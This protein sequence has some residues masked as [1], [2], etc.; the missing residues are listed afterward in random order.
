[1]V[2]SALGAINVDVKAT[3]SIAARFGNMSAIRNGDLAG[4]R[5]TEPSLVGAE[6]A[7]S[8]ASAFRLLLLWL[9]NLGDGNNNGLLN[10]FTVDQ[11]Q[12]TSAGFRNTG[13]SDWL[14]VGSNICFVANFAYR[15]FTDLGD[16]SSCT[17]SSTIS[18]RCTRAIA[19]LRTDSVA[20]GTANLRLIGQAVNAVGSAICAARF[21][22]IWVVELRLAFADLASNTRGSI[23]LSIVFVSAIKTDSVL[24]NFSDVDCLATACCFRSEEGRAQLAFRTL[25]V[26]LGRTNLRL[27]TFSINARSRAGNATFS[28]A[29]VEEASFAFSD[30]TSFTGVGVGQ[31]VLR[32]RTKRTDCVGGGAA[33]G[34]SL[35]TPNTFLAQGASRGGVGVAPES[36]VWTALI[37]ADA[38]AGAALLGQDLAYGCVGVGSTSDRGRSGLCSK[39]QG[40]EKHKG[41]FESHL[42]AD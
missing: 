14:G 4:A 16:I 26:C 12:I 40:Q 30:H 36:R 31:G 42:D 33:L 38:D 3:Q 34:D 1:V 8:S 20:T 41:R 9:L 23:S 19:A 7:V 22:V 21:F 2:R 24:T 18:T 5:R 10:T 6:S 13:S 17:A 28:L 11:D 39:A 25:S 35:L 27:I 29:F 15:I 32:A 37:A